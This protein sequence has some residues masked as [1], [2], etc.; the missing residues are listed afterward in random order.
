MFCLG[1]ITDG[2]Y[3][4]SVITGVLTFLNAMMNLVAVSCHPAFKDTA[5]IW[6]DPTLKYAAGEGVMAGAA[7]NFA[8]NNPEL[9]ARAIG[10][11]ASYAAERPQVAMQAAQAYAGA[12]AA[13]QGGG[14]GGDGSNPFAS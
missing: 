1:I 6:D 8:A 11:G 14:G 13:Q 2:S 5:S 9:A 10:A 7:T 12:Q 3:F 4:F